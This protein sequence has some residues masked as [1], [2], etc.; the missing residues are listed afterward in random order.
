MNVFFIRHGE[1][2]A[3]AKKIKSNSGDYLND[4]TP[5]GIIQIQEASKKIL[6]K[7]DCV[8]S[9]SHKRTISSA[10]IFI[11]NRFEK[12]RLQVDDRLTEINYGKYLDDLENEEL[13]KIT[14][15]QIAGDYE[16]RFGNGENKR[17]IITRFFNFLIEIF[18]KKYNKNI[19]I[20]SHGR[21]ISI[22]EHEFYKI[23]NIEKEHIH[24][25]N[26]TIK[27]LEINQTNITLLKKRLQELN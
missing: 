13:E 22:I 9:S 11:K 16:I 15:K 6:E 12:L 5:K 4:L 14:Q 25:R 26:G 1:S 24:T 10:K 21:A 3:N 17:E 2:M 19:V 27:K 20:F 23:N 8:Y 18:E 7:I